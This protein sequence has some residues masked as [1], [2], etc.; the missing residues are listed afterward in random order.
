MPLKKLHWIFKRHPF[1]YLTR[2]RLLS[3]NSDIEDIGSYDYN[4]LNKEEDIPDYFFEINQEIFKEGKPKTDFLVVKRITLWLRDH[5]KGGPGLSE[6]SEKALKTMLAGKGGVCS[7]MS[8][9]FNNFCV[10][11]QIKVREW[12][13]TTAPFNRNY[14]G[15]SFNE[16]YSYEWGK[17]ILIDPSWNLLFY[18]GTNVPLSVIEVYQHLRQ[19]VPIRYDSFNP[20][21]EL[22]I[23]NVYKNYLNPSIT[24]FLVCDYSNKT[25]DTFLERTRPFLPV[26]MT[27]FAIYLLNKSYHYRFPLDDYNKIFS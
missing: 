8:Q 2:F 3:K 15:H 25:Y 27:H 17:W 19:D 11:N 12:G 23:K 22:V 9:I 4:Q 6:P 26:F 13:T 16:F 21:R 5:I 10:I 18:N 7:D 24:P 14:G 1:L 20:N